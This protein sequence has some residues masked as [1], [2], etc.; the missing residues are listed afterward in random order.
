[1]LFF[2]DYY[3]DVG[4]N[5][6]KLQ[7]EKIQTCKKVLYFIAKSSRKVK[8]FLQKNLDIMNAIS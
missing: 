3:I 6:N 2:Y 5:N 7:N 1:M 4:K 8:T